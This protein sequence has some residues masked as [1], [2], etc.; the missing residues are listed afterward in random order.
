MCVAD[1][2]PSV[3]TTIWNLRKLAF[4]VSKDIYGDIWYLNLLYLGRLPLIAMPALVDEWVFYID[5]SKM[6]LFHKYVCQSDRSWKRETCK[7]F[8]IIFLRKASKTINSYGSQ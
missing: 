3:I 5:G 1:A 4:F 2:T 6:E 8:I 7:A